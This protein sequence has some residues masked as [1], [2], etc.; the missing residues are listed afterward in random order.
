MKILHKNRILSATVFYRKKQLPITDDFDL[1]VINDGQIQLP[2][3]LEQAENKV[4]CDE[5]MR[6]QDEGRG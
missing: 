4:I 1:S 6:C 5:K 3:K 2:E